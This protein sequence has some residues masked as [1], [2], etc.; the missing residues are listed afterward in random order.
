M[1]LHRTLIAVVFATG[2]AACGSSDFLVPVEPE[3][4]VI[5]LAVSGGLA[6]RRHTVVVDGAE[7]FAHVWCS[8]LCGG[9]TETVPLSSAQVSAFARALDEGGVLD[10]AGRDLGDGCCDFLHFD[11]T[12]DRGSRSVRVQ[13]SQDRWPTELHAVLQAISSLAT[14]AVPVLVAPS[15][16][17]SDWPTDALTLGTVNVDNLTLVAQVTYGGGCGTHRIDLVAWGA[18]LESD[19]VQV[20]ALLSHD[21]GADPCDAIVTEERSFDLRPLRAAWIEAYGAPTPGPVTIVLRLA[22]PGQPTPREI[23]LVL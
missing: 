4:I 12:Y 15:T 10:L 14:G 9:Y 19:P 13:G 18:W 5:R 6:A 2:V 23:E 16:S 7:G 3:D 1:S 21:D 22:D 8:M 11:L 17:P 20:Q